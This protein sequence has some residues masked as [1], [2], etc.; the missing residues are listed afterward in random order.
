MSDEIIDRSNNQKIKAYCN[1]CICKSC[2]NRFKKKYRKNRQDRKKYQQALEE[3]RNILNKPYPC[4][5]LEP[6]SYVNH[7]Y[8]LA[9]FFIRLI[10]EAQEKIDE[11]LN[12]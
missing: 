6:I 9:D 2:E 8:S 3:I 1:T 11:V 10:C 7:G 5:F 4:Q 12:D